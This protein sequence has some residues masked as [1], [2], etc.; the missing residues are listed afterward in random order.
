MLP[1]ALTIVSEI[2]KNNA[3]NQA[4]SDAVALVQADTPNCP[5]TGE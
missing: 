5:K 3:F 1:D 2:A 4:R